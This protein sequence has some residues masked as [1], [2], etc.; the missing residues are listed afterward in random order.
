MNTTNDFLSI[1]KCFF[2]IKNKENID[3][4]T[5]Q[6]EIILKRIFD[7]DFKLHI[8][9]NNTNE[10]FGMSVYPSESTM[11]K[12]IESILSKKSSSKELV[13]LWKDNDTWYIEIDSI[14][15]YDMKLNANPSE[16]VAVMLHEIGHIVYSQTV[17]EKLNRILRYSVMKLNYQLKVL[18]ANKK[19][20]KLF[21]LA[22]LE[23]CNSKSFSFVSDKRRESIADKFV[24]KYGYG[25]ALN[26]FITK[27][28]ASQGNSL[29]DKTESEKDNDVKIIVNWTINN[30]RELEFRKTE[31]KHAL[32]VEMLKTPSKVTRT[33][34]Q[35]IYTDFFGSVTDTYRML[36]SEQYTGESR[37]IYSEMQAE[38]NLYRTVERVLTEAKGSMFSNIGKVKKIKQSD[39]DIL[40]AESERIDTN[41][42]KIYLLDKLYAMLDTVNYS[43]ELI[44]EGKGNKVAVSKQTLL[45]QRE[46]LEKIRSNIINTKIL[47]KSYGL[48][49]RY[50]RGYEG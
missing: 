8:T 7:M 20:R 16:I 31:L 47:D 11:D 9:Q 25:E 36:L 33:T 48:W 35:N 43:L 15:L 49:V 21:N 37:D 28:I 4:N 1:E 38:S 27:L 50:P 29:V 24:V 14:L 5:R 32:K 44:D 3:E 46:Q 42:D 6:I 12:M 34:I 22:I 30:I 13:E 23:T 40:Y 17:P 19:I 45:N 41:D 26:S 10:F 18:A 2:K 39:I